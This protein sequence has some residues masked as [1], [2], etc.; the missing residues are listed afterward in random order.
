[1]MGR[2]ASTIGRDSA[3]ADAPAA[4]GRSRRTGA[5]WRAAGCTV[6]A[7]WRAMLTCATGS[8]VASWPL[9]PEQVPR[10]LRRRYP[11]EPGRWLCAETIYQAVYRP[12]L[13]GLPRELPGQVLHRRRRHRV[14]RR[15]ARRD[16]RAP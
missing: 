14:A 16:A 3:R 11:D 2:S 10:E 4:I 1:M 12:D 15:D 9:E 6:P 5:L 8:P 13:G 7:V